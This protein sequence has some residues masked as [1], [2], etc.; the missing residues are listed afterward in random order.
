MADMSIVLFKSNEG[1]SMSQ[2]A[3]KQ[4]NKSHARTD[5]TSALRLKLGQV[6]RNVNVSGLKNR[7]GRVGKTVTR[8]FQTL[9]EVWD[10]YGGGP[11]MKAVKVEVNVKSAKLRRLLDETLES[12]GALSHIRN[13]Q[14]NVLTVKIEDRINVTLSKLHVKGRIHLS[15]THLEKS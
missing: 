1:S 3:K 15:K 10:N 13:L 4:V 7:D 6:K 2:K 8:V 5:R 9:N 11:L 14:D 12:T